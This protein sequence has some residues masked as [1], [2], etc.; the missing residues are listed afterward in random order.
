MVINILKDGTQVQDLTDHIVQLKD[1]GE[2]Y[3]LLRELQK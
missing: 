2:V 3:D 1:T